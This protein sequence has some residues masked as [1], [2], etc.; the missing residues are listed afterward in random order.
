MGFFY[1]YGLG[2]EQD[3]KE[4]MRCY[5]V[6][7]ENGDIMAFNNMGEMFFLGL[8]V[9]QDFDKAMACF[10]SAADKGSEYAFFSMG[11][12]HRHGIGIKKNEREAEECTRNAIAR[13]GPKTPKSIDEF[14]QKLLNEGLKYLERKSY[15]AAFIQ[16]LLLAKTKHTEAQFQIGLMYMNGMG[17]KQ[18][19]THTVKYLTSAYKRRHPK[20]AFMLGESYMARS[21]FRRD[22]NQALFWYRKASE[23]GDGEASYR[24]A[25]LLIDTD[26]KE[27]TSEIRHYLHLAIKQRHPTAGQKLSD[28]EDQCSRSWSFIDFSGEKAFSVLAGGNVKNS[29]A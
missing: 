27:D 9:E 4:A 11:V 15:T 23:A 25:E 16:L 10:K 20:A 7:V 12:L 28:W 14:Q 17:V 8:G 24:I 21:F 13:G 1:H 2:V 29:R 3:F 18:S 22:K 5:E 26:N 19:D 6:A